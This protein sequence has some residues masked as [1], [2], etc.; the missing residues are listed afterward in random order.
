MALDKFHENVRQALINDGWIVT[1]DPISLSIKAD[2]LKIDLGAEKIIAATKAN[3]EIAV[4]VKSFTAPS[5]IYAFHLALGQFINYKNAL[6]VS[7]K[8]VNREL[9]LAITVDV[10]E[11]FFQDRPL[12]SYAMKQQ[13]LQ[14][15][16]FD[17]TKNQIKQWIK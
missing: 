16:V 7:K 17:P 1:D 14:L 6:A 12:V 13:G 3:K 8:H 4:E 11:S 2:T 15:L 9:Y 5:M 10:Y